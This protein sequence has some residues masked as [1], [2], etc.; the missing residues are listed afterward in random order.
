MK[1]IYIETYGCS[2]N[3]NNTEILLGQLKSAGLEIT[4]NEKIADLLIINTCIVKGP[5]ENKIKRRISDLQKLGKPLIVAGCMPSVRKLHGT[6]TYPL[7]IDHTKSILNL[8]RD[9]SVGRYSEKKYL[10]KRHEEK[11][12]MPKISYRK[13]IGITQ[14]S[15]GCLGNCNYCLTKLVKGSLFSY[16]EEKILKNIQSDVKSGCK[17]I[18]I[19]SQD[20]AAYGL[21]SGKN[22]LVHLLKKILEIKGKFKLRLGMMNPNNILPILD[23]LVEIYKHEK[24]YKFLHLPIQ[25]GSDK[26]LKSMNRQYK[27]K[28]FLKIVE[29]FKS[30]FPS[31]TLAT[32]VIVA[33]PSETEE[34]FTKSLNLIKRVCPDIINISKY[35]PMKKTKAAEL[36]QVDVK[37]AK[38]RALE[39]QKLHLKIALENNQKL[40]NTEK[41]ALVNEQEGSNCLART[42]DYKLVV[43]K[44]KE[45]LLGKT[46]TV[47]IISTRSHYLIAKLI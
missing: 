31:M 21:D 11:L 40:I 42:S 38:K 35:W 28:D 9:I 22:Q 13:K 34:D 1:F 46:V 10:S 39:T 17:E 47:K 16:S 45:V 23:E 24:M 44:S 2:A 3:Q 43:I 6:N 4:S 14:I 30:E 36:A 37:I 7:G 41:K 29:K 20:N 27:V 26:I 32:D 19:T 8:I 33:Y 25:S 18:W 15:E 5:T 12:C